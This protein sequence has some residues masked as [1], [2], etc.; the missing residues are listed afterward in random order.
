MFD[1]GR[2]APR[3]IV[4]AGQFMS[5]LDPAP[6]LISTPRPSDA[7]ESPDWA[8]RSEEIRCPL[9]EYNLRGLRDPRCPECGYSFI[10]SL[11]LDPA[12]RKHPYLFER[13]PE[14]NLRSFL[15]TAIG[16]LRPRRFWTSLTPVQTF[17]PRRLIAYWL[18]ATSVGVIAILTA[19]FYSIASG[20]YADPHFLANSPVYFGRSNQ[21]PIPSPPPTLREILDYWRTYVG[22]IALPFCGILIAWPWITFLALMI[23]QISMRR[24][25]IRKLHVLR[26]VL[27][28]GDFVLWLGLIALVTATS[29]LSVQ[30][31][32]STPSHDLPDAPLTWIFIG[33]WIVIA[34]RL[35][36]AYRRYL[37]FDHP[38]ATVL[39][40]QIVAALTVLV[41]AVQFSF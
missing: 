38:L 26:A 37:R 20:A 2:V 12:N 24:S 13:H 8:T 5:E 23:F 4:A 32:F 31:V 14:M 18:I 27:Y 19:S 22:P 10:W 33:C 21:P 15:K 16:G 35:Y 28:S 7:N 34:H 29:L 6:P 39:A 36:V 30:I 1:F 25:G 3:D 40:A 9:C 11:L 41:I 17:F